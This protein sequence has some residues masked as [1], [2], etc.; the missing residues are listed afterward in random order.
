MIA[1]SSLLSA[2]SSD[3]DAGA[4]LVEALG[5]PAL[6]VREAA[7]ELFESLG[8][9]G[10]AILEGLKKRDGLEGGPGIAESS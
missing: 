6:R 1:A 2:E 8:D 10:A 7:M 4:V 3:A 9:G 5:D